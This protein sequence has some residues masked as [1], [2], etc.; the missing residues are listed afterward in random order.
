[1]TPSF[2]NFSFPSLPPL[3]SG[4][5]DLNKIE[6]SSG[7]GTQNA[8]N[9]LDVR[10]PLFQTLLSY[11]QQAGSLA[12]INPNLGR[13]SL[14][15]NFAGPDQYNQGLQGG[16]DFFG[17]QGIS[18]GLGNIALQRNAA[19]AELSRM[20][21]AQPGQ[22]GLLSVLQNQNLFKSQLAGN[23]LISQAQKDTAGRITDQINL[24]NQLTQ[25]ANQTKLQ[26][27]G[28]N[29]QAQLAEYQTRLG[30]LQPQQNLLDILSSL[31]GQQRGVETVQ[32]QQLGKNFT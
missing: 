9:V 10:N 22:G 18:E 23:P 26:Q 8:T 2:S 24:Q 15:Q 16:I 17:R 5:Q 30:L 27:M 20:L 13:I 32:Q 25:L 7:V 31:Q 28:F 12:G 19:N 29:Q 11:G 21:G 3:M 6:S 14:S 1:M 4:G